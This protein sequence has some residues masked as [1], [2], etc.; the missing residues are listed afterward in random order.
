MKLH[1]PKMLTAALLAAITALGAGQQAQAGDRTAAEL[2][3]D[4][5]TGGGVTYNGHV[6]TMQ[7]DKNTS[8]ASRNFREATYNT[9]S[10]QWVDGDTVYASG[11]SDIDTPLGRGYF[12][13]MYCSA[14]NLSNAPDFGTTLRFAGATSQAKLT[15]DFSDFTI[16][17][18]IAEGDRSGAGAGSNA[19]YW[20][21]RN[22]SMDIN[23]LHD[24]NMDIN[25]HVTFSYKDS[26]NLKK[27]GTWNIHSGKTLTFNNN[28][29]TSGNDTTFIFYED[30]A[31]TVKGGGTL[32]LETRPINSGDSVIM[33]AGSSLLVTGDGTT[34]KL[35]N[36][37]AGTNTI[38]GT[39]TVET[40]SVLNVNANTTLGRTITN[41][42][43]L[44]VANGTVVTLSSDL[45]G[46]DHTA[47]YVDYTGTPGDDGFAGNLYYTI[48]K[49]TG[50]L[51]NLASVKL[52]DGT[53]QVLDENGGF[54]G[55]GSTD[56]STYHVNTNDTTVSVKSA[57]E[58]AAAQQEGAVLSTVYV[59]GAN[60]T[61]NI[62]ANFGGT[63]EV[64]GTGAVLDIQGSS[65]FTGTLTAG[66]LQG[67]GTYALANGSTS[68]GTV[69]LDS[70]EWKGTVKLSGVSSMTNINLNQYGQAGSKV[71]MDGVTG[72]FFQAADAHFAPGLVLSGTGLTINDGF[73]TLADRTTPTGFWFDGGVSGAGNLDFNHKNA[74]STVTQHLYF[75]SDV[76]DWTGALKVTRGFAVFAQFS[77]VDKQVGVSIIRENGTLNVEVG[78]GSDTSNVTFNNAITNASSLT[79]Q[80]GATA[81]LKE[82]STIGTLAGD[83]QLI[84]DAAGKTVSITG[85][86]H[87]IGKTIT[88]TNGELSL[89]GAYNLD[90]MGTTRYEQKY[91]GPEDFAV[92]G[93][94]FHE[95]SGAIQVVSIGS[96]TLSLAEGATFSFQEASVTVDDQTGEGT[97]GGVDLTTLWVNGTD[98]VS[99][100]AA[101]EYA[102]QKAPG[103]IV[104]TVRLNYDGATIT[105]DHEGATVALVLSEDEEVTSGT[106]YATKDTTISGITGWTGKELVIDG[107]STVTTPQ[108]VTLDEEGDTLVVAAGATLA[109]TGNKSN[110]TLQHGTATINGTVTIGHELD[111]SK[112]STSDATLVIGSTGSVM[113][114]DGLWLRGTRS[115]SILED[116]QFTVKGLTFIGQGEDSTILYNDVDTADGNYST[117]EAKYVITNMTIQANQDVTIGNT[118]VN[119]TVETG[120]HAVTLNTDATKVIVSDG[121]TFTKGE[122]ATVGNITVEGSGTIAGNVEVSEIGITAGSVAAFEQ[123]LPEDSGVTFSNEDAHT[124]VTVENIGEDTIHYDGIGQEDAQVTADKLTFTGGAP[125]SVANK[126]VVDEIV[127]VSGSKLTLEN[128]ESMELK[129][130]TISG[131]STVE[132]LYTNDQAALVEG[133][134]TITESL[135]AGGG[136]L[137]ANL[138]LVDGSTLDL[139]GAGENALTLGSNLAFV[140]GAIVNLDATTLDKLD[141]LVMGSSDNYLELVK[142]ATGTTLTYGEDGQGNYN[143]MWFGQLFD[144]TAGE[145]TLKGDFKVVAT[146]ESFGLTKVSNVPEPTTGTLSLL[147]LAALAA[148]RRKH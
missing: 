77:G 101:Q 19:T 56:Y 67:T 93:S 144:R 113:A 40:G 3:E 83:G 104:G 73:S 21:Y 64:A 98:P 66:T 71:G 17:G 15:T 39:I 28:S 14:A 109:I 33:R 49:N 97:F 9:E 136:T 25:A 132:M 58:Y 53:T 10:N 35:G 79:V 60:D 140:D 119:S 18:L 87:A 23:G 20:L 78:T 12:W 45:N 114:T 62:D 50:T 117:T 139:S 6:F 106:V 124:P 108:S 4:T 82:A 94:G 5:T 145:Y 111:L 146:G 24:V 95:I 30:Q 44:T 128:A 54:A 110:L 75:A 41:A 36:G 80:E 68:M 137:L 127:N 96:G 16:G 123:G 34:V 148:R 147:A 126:V 37:S 112:G 102:E 90:A 42:G 63:V 70:A 74:T 48:V 51:N 76:V 38:N 89:A 88:L 11:N 135:T 116:G 8:F 2:T 85:E 99:Y 133:T 29:T 103:T 121:G 27:G 46:F 43:T 105:M 72:Y 13:R 125:T 107:T 55:S 59:K 129:S 130:M 61:V 1:L 138:N 100:N 84:V 91:V 131:T 47:T 31:L 120:D 143:D 115:F 52:S 57:S 118:L 26:I 65:V 134:V 81:T 122:G 86:E 7:L 69:T 141:A 32:A 22:A 142:A 92:T